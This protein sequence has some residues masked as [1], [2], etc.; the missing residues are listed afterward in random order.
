VANALGGTTKK[1]APVTVNN[2]V[3][4]VNDFRMTGKEP[5]TISVQIRRPGAARSTQ[6]GFEF[7]P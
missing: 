7:K 4:Y 1:L 6:A 5:Y 3:S 2:T